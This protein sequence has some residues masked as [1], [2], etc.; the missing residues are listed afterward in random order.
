MKIVHSLTLIACFAQIIFCS[1][2]VTINVESYATVTVCSTE[3]IIEGQNRFGY[4]FS[5]IATTSGFDAE[6]KFQ[7]VL[8]DPAYAAAE[9]WVPATIEGEK[10]IIWCFVDGEKF[11]LFDKTGF[12]LPSKLDLSPIYV[13]GW[14]EYIGQNPILNLGQYCYPKFS[15]S[16]RKSKNEAFQNILDTHGNP[17]IYGTGTLD[18]EFLSNY[19]KSTDADYYEYNIKPSAYLDTN[20]GYVDCYVYVPTVSSNSGDNEIYCYYKAN[21]K[22]VFFPTVGEAYVNDDYVGLDQFDAPWEQVDIIY[23]N[24]GSYIKLTGLLFLGLLLL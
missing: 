6:Y 12:T 11:P 18:R 16:L 1:S 20:Y 5:F 24:Y 8:A 17:V 13:T 23:P 19:L 9:C 21:K 22:I 7:M 10:Q 3:H 14:E 4:G 15:S 2:D